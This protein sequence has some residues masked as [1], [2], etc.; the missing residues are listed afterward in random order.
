VAEI[1]S[2]WV[3]RPQR[4]RQ[5][6]PTTKAAR[7]RAALFAETFRQPTL[8]ALANRLVSRFDDGMSNWLSTL[9]A[10]FVGLPLSFGPPPLE[11]TRGKY[12]R[13]PLKVRGGRARAR[14][15]VRDERG[16]FVC[17][18]SSEDSGDC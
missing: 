2:P 12:A 15:A 6:R 5:L 17:E 1:H 18:A 4:A 7:Q 10:L 16:R 13:S 3:S 8:A 9:R 11:V 14:R